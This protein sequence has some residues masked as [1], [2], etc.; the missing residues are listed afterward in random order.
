MK[1]LSLF[2]VLCYSTTQAAWDPMHI[3]LLRQLPPEMASMER[4][5]DETRNVNERA[6]D[7]ELYLR[8]VLETR[9]QE[10]KVR[11]FMLISDCEADASWYCKTAIRRQ[12]DSMTTE[13][14]EP[15]WF[16]IWVPWATAGKCGIGTMFGHYSTTWAGCTYGTNIHEHFHN[17]GLHHAMRNNAEYG[18]ST[19]IMGS[20]QRTPGLNS[21]EMLQ[22]EINNTELVEITK[23]TRIVLVPAEI[24]ESSLHK[25]E[26]QHVL[27]DGVHISMRKSVG[28]PY[29]ANGDT[30]GDVF[31]H[32]T[33]VG[34]TYYEK[35]KTNWI[36]T[37]RP[38]SRVQVTPRVVIDYINYANGAALLDIEFDGVPA[39]NFLDI[40]T[41]MPE[42]V[43][44][45]DPLHNGLWYNPDFDGQGFDIQ[46]KGDRITVT[47]FTYD[48]I[49]T[50]PRWYIASGSIYDAKLDLYTAT[51]DV[52]ELIGTIQVHF[53]DSSTGVVHYNTTEHGRGTARVQA[54]FLGQ[55]D[56]SGIWTSPGIERE[57]FSGHFHGEEITLF[58]FTHGF[59]QR[60]FMLSG[61]AAEL[62]VYEVTGGRFLMYDQVDIRQ[63]GTATLDNDLLTIDL[64]V[65]SFP[66]HHELQLRRLF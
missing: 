11:G 64:E 41:D 62:G 10:I 15:E 24:P 2:L 50:A 51:P 14:F 46:I 17:L 55:D 49:R 65:L 12:M 25:E 34:D 57:G 45:I 63:V 27:I 6:Y 48:V 42:P 38:Q 47:W 37:L 22:L 26:V 56:R 39:S 54:L 21:P 19:S 52:L 58:W 66:S 5:A 35:L 33:G 36:A 18:D 31:V 44:V 16:N 29:M 23:S 13:D 8:K 32:E 53:N 3:A 60:W 40:N 43:P 20:S 9:N 28:H 59:G 61:S 4:I 7:M 1:Y 30:A